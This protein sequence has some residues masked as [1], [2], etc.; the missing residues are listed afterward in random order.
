M[1]LLITSNVVLFVVCE[2][3]DFENNKHYLD[4]MLKQGYC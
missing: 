1:F 4:K 3:M 2:E